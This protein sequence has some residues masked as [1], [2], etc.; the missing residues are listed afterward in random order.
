MDSAVDS[1]LHLPWPETVPIRQQF[2]LSTDRN[3]E[4]NTSLQGNFLR[5]HGQ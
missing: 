5:Y 1:G 4:E 2:T 3:T